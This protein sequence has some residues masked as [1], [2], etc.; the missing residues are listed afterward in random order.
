V[1][2]LQLFG[3]PGLM[4]TLGNMV[5][6]RNE[7]V[8]EIYGPQGLRKFIRD[9]LILSRSALTYDYVVC[10]I[11]VLYVFILSENKW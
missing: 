11:S 10:I 4:C 8:L 3:L 9:T 1:T 7:F 2:I 6:D 5:P